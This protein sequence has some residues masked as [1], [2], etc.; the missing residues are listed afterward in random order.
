[1]LGYHRGLIREVG[2]SRTLCQKG[3]TYKRSFKVCASTLQVFFLKT[4]LKRKICAGVG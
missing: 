1:M 3:V 2:F 4:L